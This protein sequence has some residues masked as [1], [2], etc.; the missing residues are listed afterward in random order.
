MSIRPR[1]VLTALALG[2]LLPAVLLAAS[3]RGRPVD[4]RWY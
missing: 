4:G 1:R 3:F 2:M